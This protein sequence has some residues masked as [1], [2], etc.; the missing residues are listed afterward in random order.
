MSKQYYLL[1]FFF[2]DI[3]FLKGRALVAASQFA[4]QLPQEL[5]SRYVVATVDAIQQNGAIPVKVSALRAL[6][7]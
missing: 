6:Q 1:L 3:P 4:A 7:K 5:A 2:T